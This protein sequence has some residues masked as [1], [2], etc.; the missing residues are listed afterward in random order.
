MLIKQ[1]WAVHTVLFA[2]AYIKNTFIVVYEQETPII[3]EYERWRRDGDV[4]GGK[5]VRF[6]LGIPGFNSLVEPYQRPQKRY[7][8]FL[9]GAMKEVIRRKS[10]HVR[11]L[12]P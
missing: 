10:K 1:V 5:S 3:H 9:L 2:V 7:S 8:V 4:V 6:A 11:L 12:R